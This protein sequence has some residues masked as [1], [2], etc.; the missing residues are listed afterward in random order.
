MA[1]TGNH[2]GM[3][4][5][6]QSMQMVQQLQYQLAQ[7]VISDGYGGGAPAATMA[8]SQL[9]QQQQQQQLQLQQ[10]QQQ[11]DM[12]MQQL[13]LQQQAAAAAMNG[14]GGGGGSRVRSQIGVAPSPAATKPSSGE[15][16]R[17]N[18]ARQPVDAASVQRRTVELQ[19]QGPVKYHASRALVSRARPVA[20]ARSNDATRSSMS[21][22]SVFVLVCLVFRFPIFPSSAILTSY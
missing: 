1:Q 5:A 19:L 15:R 11:Q 13:Q 14:S 18:T 20:R 7:Q 17:K 22:L 3:A 10:Q 9:Q 12:H 16:K 2:Q 4:S 6:Q 21:V 8:S